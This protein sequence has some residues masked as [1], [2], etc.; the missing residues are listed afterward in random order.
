MVS[1]DVFAIIIQFFLK[2]KKTFLSSVVI[3]MY[4]ESH[5]IIEN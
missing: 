5:F 1:A 2:E 4:S 3:W